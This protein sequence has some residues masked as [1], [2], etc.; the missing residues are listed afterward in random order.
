MLV[1]FMSPVMFSNSFSAVN[2]PLKY[3]VLLQNNFG[4][5]LPLKSLE[6]RLSYGKLNSRRQ[7]NLLSVFHRNSPKYSNDQR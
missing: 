3:E 4:Q 6:I 7:G 1:A 5:L 2:F